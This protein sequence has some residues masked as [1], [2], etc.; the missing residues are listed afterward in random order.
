MS[1]FA[2]LNGVGRITS[3]QTQVG[4]RNL[5]DQERI[6][7]DAVGQVVEIAFFAVFEKEVKFHTFQDVATRADIFKEEEL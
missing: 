4:L 5:H 7:D 2:H 1:R 6:D 3:G